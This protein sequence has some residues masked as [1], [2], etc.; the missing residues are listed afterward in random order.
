MKKTG[1]FLWLGCIWLLSRMPVVRAEVQRKC[2]SSHPF[3]AVVFVRVLLAVFTALAIITVE[4]VSND[5]QP[6][7]TWVG[8]ST[9]IIFVFIIA[10]Q[11]I[12]F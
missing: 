6:A 7:E 1:A 12:I 3:K 11:P 10:N 4:E 8:P 9:L 2:Y 5:W